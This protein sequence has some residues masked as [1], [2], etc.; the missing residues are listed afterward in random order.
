MGTL[1]RQQSLTSRRCARRTA[2]FKTCA[3]RSSIL[4]INFWGYFRIRMASSY[5]RF[6]RT[7]LT[8]LDSGWLLFLTPSTTCHAI[9][10]HP[11]VFQ[12]KTYS[13]LSCSPNLP[14]TTSFSCPLDHPLT[15]LERRL[16]TPWNTRWNTRWKNLSE[17]QRPS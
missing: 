11:L 3:V 12:K 16:N 5:A 17:E 14:L 7:G 9:D 2:I 13:G 10:R 6:W 8:L 4:Y 15:C 1:G